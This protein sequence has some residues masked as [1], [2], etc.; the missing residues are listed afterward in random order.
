MNGR[1][2]CEACGPL[3]A[4]CHHAGCRQ[5]G[6]EAE[7]EIVVLDRRLDFDSQRF[8]FFNQ[9]GEQVGRTPEQ[10]QAAISRQIGHMR[11][12]GMRRRR[13][14]SRRDQDAPRVVG[15]VSS[16]HFF[17]L[18][19]QYGESMLQNVSDLARQEGTYWGDT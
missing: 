5:I 3:G 7:V 6:V 16:T 19:K 17:G 4:A 11:R 9:T 18:R 8:A 14:R 12:D 1:H 2:W 10:Q 13:E 15:A